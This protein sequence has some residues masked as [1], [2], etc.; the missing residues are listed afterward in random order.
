MKH[1]TQHPLQSIARSLL[2]AESLLLREA[3]RFVSI[4]LSDPGNAAPERSSLQLV[5]HDTQCGVHQHRRMRKGA[6]E[7]GV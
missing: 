3:C 4:N 7:G 5:F 1:D 6:G 2:I